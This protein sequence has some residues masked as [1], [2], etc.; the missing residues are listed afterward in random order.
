IRPTFDCARRGPRTIRRVYGS[1]TESKWTSSSW[2]WM[3][4][5]S[6][7]WGGRNSAHVEP[8]RG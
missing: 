8:P 3:K 7:Q 4:C 5:G 6:G 2:Y 1:G